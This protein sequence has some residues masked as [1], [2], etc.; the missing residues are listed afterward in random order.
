MQRVIVVFFFYKFFFMAEKNV[1]CP[2]LI[3]LFSSV[4]HGLEATTSFLL[5]LR[6]F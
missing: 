6:S 3:L 4:Y 2:L 1:L 5:S